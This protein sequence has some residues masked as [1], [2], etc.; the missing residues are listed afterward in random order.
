[1]GTADETGGGAGARTVTLRE[2][3]DGA[4]T[5]SLHARLDAQGNLCIEGHD[6]GPTVSGLL[7][8]SEYEWAISV[9][10]EAVPAYVQVLGGAPGDD[11][12][13][14]LRVAIADQPD[15]ADLA[16]LR[17]CGVPCSFWS[18]VGD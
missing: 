16:F 9:A 7:G 12:L 2:A 10:A 13:D 18:R 5:R 6:L 11:A 1:M 3:R 4:D 8:G 14:C 17:R 15:C